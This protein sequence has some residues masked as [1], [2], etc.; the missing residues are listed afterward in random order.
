[1]ATVRMLR[2]Y[3]RYVKLLQV[4]KRLIHIQSSS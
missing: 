2:K 4:L 3:V 1:M